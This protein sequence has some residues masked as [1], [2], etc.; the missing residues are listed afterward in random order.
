MRLLSIELINWRAFAEARFEFKSDETKNLVVIGAPNGHGKTSFF[1]A[2]TLCL[3]GKAGLA[4]LA[5]ASEQEFGRPSISYDNFLRQV[6]HLEALKTT[7]RITINI[8]L[9]RPTVMS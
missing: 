9:K 7:R 1:E 2:V 6:L 5:R 4:L 8:S 3:Y